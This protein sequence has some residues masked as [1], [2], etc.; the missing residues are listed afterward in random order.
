MPDDS[1]AALPLIGFVAGLALAPLLVNGVAFAWGGV[2][3]AVLFLVW[4]RALRPPGPAKAPA[5]T[6]VLVLVFAALGVFVAMRDA[7]HREAESRAL[8]ALDPDRFVII[9]APLERD[10]S[11]RGDSFLLRASH[12]KANGIEIEQPVA[13]YARFPPP[14]PA[15]FA[16]VRAEAFVKR[17]ER[18]QYVVSIKS[19]L[20]LEYRGALRWWQPAAWNRA[21][22]NRIRPLAR[23]HPDEVALIEALVLGRGE[24]LGDEARDEFKRA[25]TYHLLV[26]SG[27]QIALAAGLIALLLRWLHAPRVADWSLLAFAILAPL[28]IGPTASVARASGGIAL[29]AISRI[30]KRP[31]TLENLWC[32]S[33]LIR[34]LFA[35]FELTDAAFQLTY[36]G[37]GALLF[38]GKTLGKGKW[39]WI[40]CAVAAE[41]AVTP[42]TLFHFHQ[43]ALGGSLTTIVLTP[44][45]FAMLIAGAVICI[46]PSAKLLMAIT[47]LNALCGVANRIAAHG[48]GFFASPPIVAML[49]GFACALL[50]IAFFAGRRRAIAML[51]ALS[52]PS[53]AAIARD[54]DGRRVDAPRVIMLDVGQGDSILV[55][56]GERTMLVDGG[57]SEANVVTQLVDRGVRHLDVV[58]LTHAHPDHCGGLP[59]VIARLDVGEVWISPRRF[60]G[61]CATRLLEACAARE[62][63]IRLLRERRSRTLGNIIITPLLARYTFK[64]APEN[65]S[66]V[67]LRLRIGGRRVLLTGDIERDAERELAD[68]EDIR[69]DVL[70]IA[71]HGSR[72]S[73]TPALLDAVRPRIALISCGRRNLFG[74]PHPSVVEALR[75]RKIRIAETDRNGAVEVVFFRQ[76]IDVRSEIDTP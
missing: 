7:N 3:I 38:A 51:I 39:R 70:K 15:M 60:R 69:A 18:G 43:F 36:A 14:P 28:F 37:A 71:H 40:G 17:S 67:V 2:A 12:F 65:N 59:A 44:L 23:E 26:F 11:P 73:S 72:T 58:V 20:L 4:R 35:P 45:V 22:A 76:H 30:L 66:S 8:A 49:I 34:L 6:V 63:P 50:A 42:L 5:P 25:G 47:F 62:T 24:R 29:F 10:W 16:T 9:E 61:D 48:S 53:I 75:E 33:A 57:I 13:L 32:V 52:M 54:R 64:R 74:H 68:D 56:D 46:I 21:L 31:T 55:R 1:P 27:L 19:P 41:L